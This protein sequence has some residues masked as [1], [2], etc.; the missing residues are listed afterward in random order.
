MAAVGGWRIYH[1]SIVFVRQD[2]RTPKTSV[3]ARRLLD[4]LTVSRKHTW[5]IMYEAYVLCRP[6]K[7]VQSMFSEKSNVFLHVVFFRIS[8]RYYYY[9][10]NDSDITRCNLC[11]CFWFLAIHHFQA[12]W[13]AIC[14]TNA[15][16]IYIRDRARLAWIFN[17]ARGSYTG[18]RSRTAV[19]N[20]VSHVV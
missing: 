20:F 15:P 17:N 16:Y 18:K 8:T 12:H 5:S 6:M 3:K 14:G 10:C 19:I 7:R 2:E 9:C 13:R 11:P 1:S 4:I